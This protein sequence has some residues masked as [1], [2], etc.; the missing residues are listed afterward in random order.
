MHMA[1]ALM[2]P[3]VAV[4]AGAAAAALIV[5][6]AN[7]IKG[8]SREG[9]TSMMGIMGAF[10]FAAQMINFTIPGTGSSGH[11]IGGIMLAALLGPWAAFL[12]LSSVLI[13]QC[14]VFADGGLMA[15]GCNIINMAAMSCLVAYPLIFRPIMRRGISSRR[16]M[17]SSV[18]S[19]VAGLLLGA[20]LVS[21]ETVL[22]GVTALPCVTFL[23]VMI[24]IHLVIGAC[25]GVATGLV[26]M[27][28]FRSSPS[29]LYGETGEASS[30]ESSRRKVLIAFAATAIV[31]AVGFTWLASSD[32]DG[33]EWSIERITGST[34][35]APAAAPVTAVI[36]DYESYFAGIVGAIIV[37]VMLW[38][39]SALIFR[40]RRC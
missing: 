14:L 8:S 7:K 30:S 18:L 20:F 34:E 12:T 19:S 5:V 15:L 36:P 17:W 6:S 37:M 2:S 35:L 13:V 39:L 16:L 23:S 4:T 10:V 3:A 11:I 1:D 32:P 33:L 25:E 38:A 21:V 27:F 26:L 28:V 29:L 22:S 31:L 24:P 40:H 9:L